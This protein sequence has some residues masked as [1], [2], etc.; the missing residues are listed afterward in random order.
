MLHQKKETLPNQI[1]QR[2]TIA[3]RE[4]FSMKKDIKLLVNAIETKNLRVFIS[5]LH[6]TTQDDI[7][8]CD[9]QT[10]LNVIHYCAQMNASKELLLII[11]Y[12]KDV[13]LN[14]KTQNIVEKPSLELAINQGNKDVATIL[15]KNGAYIN[16]IKKAKDLFKD[17]MKTL[18]LIN[19]VYKIQQ[20]IKNNDK[21]KWYH[22]FSVKK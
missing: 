18:E 2:S 16:Q 13:N 20:P 3:N 9:E 12:I 17:D 21:K 8:Q 10:G 5:L 19:N 4:A 11:N 6:G 7:E 22:F 14:I 15:I 1:E